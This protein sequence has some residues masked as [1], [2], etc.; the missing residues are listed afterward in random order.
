MLSS[1]PDS[2]EDSAVSAPIDAGGEEQEEE[3]DSPAESDVLEEE[4]DA[5]ANPWYVTVKKKDKVP[6][7]YDFKKSW[8][9]INSTNHYWSACSLIPFYSCYLL[10]SVLTDQKYIHLSNQFLSSALLK[11]V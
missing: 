4:V 6:L 5:H 3:E 11:S 10:F 7:I 1:D 8:R 9:N 2:A